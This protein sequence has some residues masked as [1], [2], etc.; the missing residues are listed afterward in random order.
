M[1]RQIL[2]PAGAMVV[3]LGAFLPIHTAAAQEAGRREPVIG[4]FRI[5]AFAGADT[6]GYE[7]GA[8]YGGRI[9]YDLPISDN[10]LLGVDAELNDVTTEQTIDGVPIV[11]EDGPDYYVGGRIGLRLSRRFSLIGGLGYTRARQGSFFLVDPNQPQGPI[12]GRESYQDGYRVTLGGQLGIGRRAFLGAEYRYSN[13][14]E[15]FV[16]RGQIVASVG[17][18]F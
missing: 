9:G 11:L 12:D 1:L 18:R 6:D 5:E 4:G 8:V 10:L 16:A 14:G 15:G 7:H 13:Y 17:I 3:A 2:M